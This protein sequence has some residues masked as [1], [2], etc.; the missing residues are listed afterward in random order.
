VGLSFH[1][2]K[3]L[4]AQAAIICITST[5]GNSLEL[6][7]SLRPRDLACVHAVNSGLLIKRDH[8]RINLLEPADRRALFKAEF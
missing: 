6:P 5:T 1:H 7:E 8:E 3:E 2:L 4:G